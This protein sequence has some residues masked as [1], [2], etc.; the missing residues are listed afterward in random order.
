M[1]STGSPQEKPVTVTEHEQQ[2]QARGW[3]GVPFLAR[4]WGVSSKV[5]RDIPR[6]RLP[7]ISF[8]QSD[9]RRYDPADIAAFEEREKRGAAA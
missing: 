2:L 4:R 9:M 6:D 7:Y 8:G 5:V 1:S 3:P